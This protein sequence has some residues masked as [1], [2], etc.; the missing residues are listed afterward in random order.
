VY[1]ARKSCCICVKQSLAALTEVHVPKPLILDF[2]A[3]KAHLA[4]VLGHSLLDVYLGA[5]SKYHGNW[6]GNRLAVT[7]CVNTK[8][9]LFSR[10][11]KRRFV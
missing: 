4:R 11:K 6:Y 7:I 3:G 9:L 10:G 5:E 1:A 8:T 2:A